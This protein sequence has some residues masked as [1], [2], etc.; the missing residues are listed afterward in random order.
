M[1]SEAA[2]EV[3]VAYRVV[4]LKCLDWYQHTLSDLVK[5]L[6]SVMK[7]VVKEAGYKFPKSKDVDKLSRKLS[8]LLR[9]RIE[10][11]SQSERIVV[12]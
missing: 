11:P 6:T 4:L 10:R 5:E 9:K 2:Y 7:P 8:K 3:A 1:K 12:E